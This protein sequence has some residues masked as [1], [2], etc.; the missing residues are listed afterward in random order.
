MTGSKLSLTVIDR[1]TGK[2]YLGVLPQDIS[3]EFDKNSL[4][5]SPAVMKFSPGESTFFDL[6]QKNI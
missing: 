4:E 6:K 5:V 3:I 1:R 2:P